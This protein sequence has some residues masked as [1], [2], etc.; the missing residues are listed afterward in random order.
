MIYKSHIFWMLFLTM[1]HC[2]P[3]HG[4]IAAARA[5]FGINSQSPSMRFATPIIINASTLPLP[6]PHYIPSQSVHSFPQ[7]SQQEK[8]KREFI[9]RIEG[10]ETERKLML[11]QHKEL[12]NNLDQIEAYSAYLL[13]NP[14]FSLANLFNCSRLVRSIKYKNQ[15]ISNIDNKI[16]IL[17]EASK[18][19][20]KDTKTL[21]NHLSLLED[22]HWS[23]KRMIFASYI[24]H[25]WVCF[26]T[27]LPLVQNDVVSLLFAIPC[28]FISLHFAK[29]ASKMSSEK[30]R[31]L[32]PLFREILK[33]RAKDD[34]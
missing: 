33:A 9:S 14:N 17:R 12:K 26:S 20:S 34:N 24:T 19:F 16:E 4:M 25:P 10:L 23:H 21:E 2:A 6:R 11:A 29:Q 8:L 31:Q 13:N 32:R 5:A 30:V 15:E 28:R 27:M 22:I 18:S 3:S 1:I 7:E